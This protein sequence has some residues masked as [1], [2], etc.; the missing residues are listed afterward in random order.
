MSD[1]APTFVFE[2][3]KVFAFHE[4]AV[5][6]SGLEGEYAA[7]E[8]TAVEYLEALD[9]ERKEAAVAKA[10][11]TATTI[12]TPNGV[13]GEILSRTS[14][15]W[16]DEQVTVRLANGQITQFNIHAS[17]EDKW[18]WVNRTE[19]TA[20][21]SR[22]AKLEERVAADFGHDKASLEARS[23]ELQAVASEASQLIA[24]GVSLADAEK[25][26]EIKLAADHER[27]EI[28]DVLAHLE[29]SD[30]E[31]F[32]PP[33]S[34]VI[35]QASMGRAA[36]DS[37]LDRLAQDMV[38]QTDGQDFA[39]LLREGPELFVSDLDLGA[40]ADTGVT[41]EMALSHVASKT[42][43]YAGDDVDEFRDKFIARVEV[44]RRAELAARKAETK[45]EVVAKVEDDA[46]APDEALFF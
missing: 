23:D 16:G 33:T 31:A 3:G 41:R 35:E 39:K 26:D 2:N 21:V 43:G 7:V 19:K 38:E 37:W 36:N 45:R 20:G 11:K 32:V 29:D 12:I 44:A 8:Q 6:A 22:V 46:N 15:V 27:R 28:A 4:G 30:I 25:L 5:I 34:A 18:Q 40:L 14:S 17:T 1:L 10:K 13:E 24:N 9:K 42:A